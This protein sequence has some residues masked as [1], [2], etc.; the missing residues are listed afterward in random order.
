MAENDVVKMNKLTELFSTSSNG[1]SYCLYTNRHI[2]YRLI[3]TSNKYYNCSM[4][5]NTLN[6][7]QQ[8]VHSFLTIGDVAIT[9]SENMMLL[10]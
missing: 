1:F 9:K 2:Y 3:I 6:D 7:F 5:F 10:K 4:D 8:F